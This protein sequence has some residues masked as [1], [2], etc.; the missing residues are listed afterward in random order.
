MNYVA[1]DPKAGK[2]LLGDLVWSALPDAPV[3]E[4]RPRFVRVRAWLSYVRQ[5]Y[6]SV[7]M[8]RWSHAH[9]D[10]AQ[11]ATSPSARTR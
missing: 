7:A 2:P 9:R 1:L 11:V 5:T 6:F 10:S 3:Q 4:D 8:E